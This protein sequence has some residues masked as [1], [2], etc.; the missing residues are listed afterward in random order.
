M[1]TLS[2][3]SGPFTPRM[4]NLWRSWTENKKCVSWAG[5]DVSGKGRV[6]YYGSTC[7]T[8][9]SSPQ[10]VRTGQEDG[11]TKGSIQGENLPINPLNLLNVR[12]ILTCGFTSIRTPLAVWM[13]TCSR[14]AL[15]SGESSSVSRHCQKHKKQYQID[16]HLIDQPKTKKFDRWT[17]KGH[18][19]MPNTPD[20]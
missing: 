14:P 12:G 19:K 2:S 18:N 13:Y 3:F 11:N 16:N 20:V 4:D 5:K 8:R 9:H 7:Y 10:S 17:D 15:F 6:G 1:T